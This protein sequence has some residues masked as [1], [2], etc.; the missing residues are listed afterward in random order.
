LIAYRFLSPE[1]RPVPEAALRRAV[2]T[3]AHPEV[4]VP[5][6]SGVS[7]PSAQTFPQ[8]ALREFPRP[9]SAGKKI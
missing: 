3:L 8:R 6:H 9:P 2:I 1:P 7:R 5:T 4:L